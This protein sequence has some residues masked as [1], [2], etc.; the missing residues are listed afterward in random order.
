LKQ[1]ALNV[2]NV[3]GSVRRAVEQNHYFIEQRL[4]LGTVSEGF[5]GL[6]GYAGS[7]L[8]WEPEA[9][10]DVILHETWG[11]AAGEA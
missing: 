9:G 10:A 11:L 2:K 6:G 3:V 7:K 4:K 5:S 1:K 8:G